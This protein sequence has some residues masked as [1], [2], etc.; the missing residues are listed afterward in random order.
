MKESAAWLLAA[1][2]VFGPAARG[3]AQTAGPQ[4]PEVF[5]KV[6]MVFLSGDDAETV[7]V[8]LRLDADALVVE[9]PK[10]GAVLKRLAY[11]DIKAAEYSY[12]KHPR[13]KAGA[14]TAAG[15]LLFA[16]LTLLALPVAI[17]LAFSKSKRHWLTVRTGQ[18]YAVFRLGKEARKLIIP[19][20]EVRAGVTVEPVGENK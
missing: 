5:E 3:A 17:P 16:P 13:W 10:T 19:A 1:A 18:D 4:R 11:A 15:A 9:S 2:L 14:G 6:E 7:R 8:R 20:F 12:S